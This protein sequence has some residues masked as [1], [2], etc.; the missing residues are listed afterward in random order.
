MISWILFF[1]QSL[2]AAFTVLWR[3]VTF[4]NGIQMKYIETGVYVLA[5]GMF[6]QAT[7]EYPEKFLWFQKWKR[8]ILPVFSFIIVLI[9][10]NNSGNKDF[11]YEK[12]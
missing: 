2:S 9:L 8:F 10:L 3:L 4:Q 12:F 11:F 5:V 1:T 6:F 7:E